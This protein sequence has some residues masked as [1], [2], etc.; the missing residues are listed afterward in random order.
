MELYN[1]TADPHQI[2]NLMY[3]QLE[4]SVAPYLGLVNQA[5]KLIGWLGNCVGSQCYTIPESV[6]DAP[7]VTLD[8]LIDRIKGRL[9]CDL[10]PGDEFDPMAGIFNTT[11]NPARRR[12]LWAKDLDVPK[13]FGHGHFGFADSDEV[14]QELL[15]QWDRVKEYFH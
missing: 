14:P 6:F 3:P 5:S 12:R 2:D 1:N 9:P 15:E 13:V 4:A 7:D 8:T 11:G 10:P